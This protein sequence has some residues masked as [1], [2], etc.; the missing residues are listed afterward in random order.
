M[1]A[2]A[3]LDKLPLTMQDKELDWKIITVVVENPGMSADMVGK[4]VGISVYQALPITKELVATSLFLGHFK[5]L[6]TSFIWLSKSC[7]F[8]QTSSI[9]LLFP[10]S[11]CRSVE[12]YLL[13]TFN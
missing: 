10:C 8:V 1:I 6:S 2:E 3:W 7:F 9:R 4:R 5:I 13:V 11:F 12:E